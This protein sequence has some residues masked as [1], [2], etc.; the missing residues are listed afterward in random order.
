MSKITTI[1]KAPD[2]RSRA[3]NTKF[4]IS[5][6]IHSF[7]RQ[8]DIYCFNYVALEELIQLAELY[9]IRKYNEEFIYLE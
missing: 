2:D 9:K 4:G 1:D 3:E 6:I 7:N 5:N 8:C